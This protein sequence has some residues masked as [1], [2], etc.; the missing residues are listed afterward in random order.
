MFVACLR[1]I[2][3][4]CSWHSGCP[5]LSKFKAI[6]ESVIPEK[7]GENFK[8]DGILLIFVLELLAKNKDH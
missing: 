1:D 8:L 6:T 5:G 3:F 7:V 2:F 4:V